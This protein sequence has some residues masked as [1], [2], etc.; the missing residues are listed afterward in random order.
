MAEKCDKIIKQGKRKGEKC[1]LVCCRDSDKCAYHTLDSAKYKRKSYSCK[2][3][4]NIISK[5]KAHLEEKKIMLKALKK[6]Y[7]R[8]TRELNGIRIFLKEIEVRS[9]VKYIK[10]TTQTTKY[11]TLAQKDTLQ[12]RKKF[13]KAENKSLLRHIAKLE[14]ALEALEDTESESESEEKYIIDI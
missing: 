14:K 11:N 1:D 2:K 6:D 5:T 9:N 3:Y 8:V 7:K 13:L 12:K 4:Q 10:Y